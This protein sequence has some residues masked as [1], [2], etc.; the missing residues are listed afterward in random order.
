MNTV[1][2]VHLKLKWRFFVPI[3]NKNKTK[4]KRKIPKTKEKYKNRKD[5]ARKNKTI[6]IALKP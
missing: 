4:H 5:K 2:F 3:F 1:L 6:P